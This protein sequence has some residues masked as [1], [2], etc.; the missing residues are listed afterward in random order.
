MQ[1]TD[2]LVYSS[3][4]VAVKA[5]DTR[6]DANPNSL[7][8]PEYTTA[9]VDGTSMAQ[10]A[11]QRFPQA[12][13]LTLPETLPLSEIFVAVANGKADFATNGYDGALKFMEKNPG[14]IKILQNSSGDKPL[15]VAAMPW[16][17]YVGKHEHALAETLN[18]G[19]AEL[20]AFNLIDPIVARY[21]PTPGVYKSVHPGHQ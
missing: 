15:E 14:E 6:F 5:N 17:M 7:N 12:K 11:R 9:I 18:G 10:V 19:L 21:A 13:Q 2:P 1:P 16:V 8:N 20:R 4:V 3:V